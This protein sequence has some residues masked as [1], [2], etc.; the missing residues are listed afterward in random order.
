MS[1][2]ARTSGVPT[3]PAIVSRSKLVV[4]RTIAVSLPAGH[5]QTDGLADQVADSLAK[6]GLAP[7][8]L[9]LS[10]TEETLLTSAAGLVTELEATRRIGVRLCMD[11]YGMGHSIFAL[12]ARVSLDILRADLNTLAP[13]DDTDRALMV[14]GMIAR[15]A[16]SFGLTSIA[17]GVTAE[18]RAGVV[19]GCVDLLHGRSEP[20]DLTVEE[21]AVLV[22]GGDPVPAA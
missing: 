15:T 9:V 13:R 18:L 8:R 6:S 4:V 1:T 2:D 17:G 14:M 10:I 11:N 21:L 16:A 5:V 22:S 19:A 7:S 20:H 12:L 3:P